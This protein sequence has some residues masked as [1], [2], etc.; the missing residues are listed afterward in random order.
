MSPHDEAS[1]TS[2]ILGLA[3][4]ALLFATGCPASRSTTRCVIVASPAPPEV[5][6]ASSA[7]PGAQPPQLTFASA[8][9]AADPVRVRPLRQV[10]VRCGGAEG[11]HPVDDLTAMLR[12]SVTTA[13]QTRQVCPAFPSALVAEAPGI[14]DP[15]CGASACPNLQFRS[16]QQGTAL[17]FLF[18]DDPGRH[19]PDRPCYYRLYAVSISWDG[20]GPQ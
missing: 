16:E 6:P 12:G 5:A 8:N 4:V 9:P 11:D 20:P 1:R 19:G 10:P 14:K 13:G 3:A 18:H 2:F 7:P 17:H 15:P